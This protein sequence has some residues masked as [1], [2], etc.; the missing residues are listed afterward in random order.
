MTGKEP[1]PQTV[2]TTSE[3]DPLYTDVGGNLTQ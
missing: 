3:L 1:S 2:V